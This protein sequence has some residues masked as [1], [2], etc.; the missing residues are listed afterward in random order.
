MARSKAKNQGRARKQKGGSWESKLAKDLTYYSSYGNEFRKV[1][2]SGAYMGGTN[3]AKNLGINTGAQVALSGDILGPDGWC[4]S[5]ECK[6]TK[7]Y[8]RFHLMFDKGDTAVD[9]FLQETCFDAYWNNLIPLLA[10]KRTFQGE[11]MMVPRML[12]IY[13]LEHGK[14]MIDQDTYTR[15]DY[16]Y[17][18]DELI[19]KDPEVPIYTRNWVMFDCAFFNFYVETFWEAGLALI[20]D[21]EKNNNDQP[22]SPS[23]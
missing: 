20:K 14:G 6:N 11:F 23:S 12:E 22:L 19:Q 8:P 5:I 9:G 4:F 2:G 7:A 17:R 13:F 10:M 18:G 21:N 1:V 15:M 3:R 16:I